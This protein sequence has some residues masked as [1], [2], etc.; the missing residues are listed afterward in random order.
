MWNY[1]WARRICTI[2]DKLVATMDDIN[3]V[4]GRNNSY[5]Q[6]LN[7]FNQG[8]SFRQSPGMFRAQHMQNQRPRQEER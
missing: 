2:D 6:Y 8:H 5:N 3:F 1:A 7:N 4:E